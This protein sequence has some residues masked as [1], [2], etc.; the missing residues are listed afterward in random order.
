[1]ADRW[2]PG[3][4]DAQI[5]ELLLPAGIDLP[6]EAR[7][8]W[9]WHDGQQVAADGTV[10]TLGGRQF[11]SLEYSVEWYEN[12][13]GLFCEAEGVDGLLLALLEQ[14]VLHFDCSRGRNQPV[15]VYAVPHGAPAEVVCGS[16]GDLVLA[17]EELFD[18]EALSV[19]AEGDV[20][21]DWEIAPAHLH[22]V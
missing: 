12:F 1:L 6:E 3:L 17:I 11:P 13:R 14:P 4:S 2:R 7:V 9:R 16:I 15:P 18:C 19:N 10:L 20:V 21:Y 22:F 5:D 8:W